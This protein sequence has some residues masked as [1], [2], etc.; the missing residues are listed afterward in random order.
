MHQL[1][2]RNRAGMLLQ[3]G[4]LER[5]QNRRNQSRLDRSVQRKERGSH[6]ELTARLTLRAAAA[7]HI[8]QGQGNSALSRH[9]RAQDKTHTAGL[10][11]NL[12]RGQ[13]LSR[14]L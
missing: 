4:L 3:L 11:A 5:T 14:I 8:R 2:I 10:G 7:R 1:S 6:R 12:L 9:I 13:A